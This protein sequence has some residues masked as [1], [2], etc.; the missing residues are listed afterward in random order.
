MDMKN[1]IIKVGILSLAF[2]AAVSCTGNYLK[3]N[4]NPYEVDEEQMR[5]D[6]YIIGATLS[7]ICGTVVSTDVNTA[8]FTDCLLGGPMGGYYSSTGSWSKTIDNFNAT[9]DWTRVFMYSDH[10]IPT[11]FTNLRELKKI[12][13]DRIVHSMANVVKVAAMQRVTDTY[14]PIPYSNIGVDAEITVPYDSQE[15]VYD[16][17]FDE[18]DEAITVLEDNID[19]TYS[20]NADPVYRGSIRNWCKLANS[21]KLRLAMRIVYTEGG[22]EKAA[23]K[24]KE[25]MEHPVGAFTSNADNAALQ[26]VAFGDKGNPLYTAVKYNQI[27][28]SETGGDTHAAAEI[29]SYMTAYNDPRC[30]K[31]FIKSEFADKDFMY[32][33]ALISVV[34]P[35]LGTVGRKY[36][37]VNIGYNDPLQWMNAAEVAFLKAEAVVLGVISGDAGEYYNEGIRLSF[38]QHGVASAYAAY[39][40]NEEKAPVTYVNPEGES[41]PA[42][43][44]DIAVKWDDAATVAEKQERIIIQKW[45]ANFNL[46]NEAWA[47]HRRT[48]YPKFFPA[49]DE[50]NMSGGIVDNSFGARRMPYPQDERTTNAEN[51]SYAVANLLGGRDNMAT[52]VWWDCNPAV[53]K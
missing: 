4:T 36:A 45:I 41:R 43:L 16:K 3:I 25:V 33:G 30:E 35:P 37:G 20:A 29:T 10:I 39:I 6:D 28:G 13:D 8:Q 48:G 12:T 44:T 27:A 47:D 2:F 11:L 40:G 15:Q 7:A 26:P 19:L 22:K 14:G 18:L 5:Q 52:R 1:S 50:G 42:A 46:G 53:N 24:F 49:S 21:L 23:R 32:T 17:M 51:Y 31:Y 9:D 34:K 38:D